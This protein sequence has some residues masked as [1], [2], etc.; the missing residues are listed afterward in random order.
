VHRSDGSGTTAIFTD[1]LS[2]VSADWKG[3]VG[4]NTSVEWPSGIGAKGNEGVANNVAQTRGAIGYVE[5]AYAKQNKLTH[6]RM[7]NKNGK[8]IEPTAEAFTAA[9]ANADWEG[10]PGFAIMLT[11]EPGDQAWPISGATFILMHKQ[12]QDPVAAKEALKFFAWAYEKGDDAAMALDYVP[13]PNNVVASIK[14]VWS[15]SVTDAS[16]KPIF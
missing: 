2:K 16:G 6:A 3:K 14:K 1:Y 8:A 13:M 12:P 11:D 7:I 4:S 9:A 5:Y 10:T 15:G